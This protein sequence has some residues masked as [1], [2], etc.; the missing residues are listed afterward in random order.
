MNGNETVAQAVRRYGAICKRSK[1]KSKI[2]KGIPDC[3]RGQVWT[4]LADINTIVKDGHYNQLVFISS[5]SPAAHDIQLDL[6]RTFPDHPM[7]KEEGPGQAALCR[8]LTAYS[9]YD[10][11]LGYC[12]DS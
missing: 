2:R 5:N 9:F 7:F 1:L 10:P 12:Q 8:V 6:S 4:L 3:L 11:E